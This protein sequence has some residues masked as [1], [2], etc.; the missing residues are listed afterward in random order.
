MCKN[1][2]LQL[3]RCVHV[4]AGEVVWKASLGSAVYSPPCMLGQ[5]DDGVQ[6][7]FASQFGCLH[8]FSGSSGRLLW[9]P[10]PAYEDSARTGASVRTNV[11]AWSELTSSPLLDGQV[12]NCS[13]RAVSCASNGAITLLEVRITGGCN[14]LAACQLGSEVYSPPVAFG[15]F[16]LCGCRDDYLYCLHMNQ[17]RERK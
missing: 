13:S 7:T 2:N 3:C 14:T 17:I 8:S 4:C 11:T 9:S 5:L 6:V 1:S 10:P 15:P 16:I 12:R